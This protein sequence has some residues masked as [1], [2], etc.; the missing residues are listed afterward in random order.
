M[1]ALTFCRIPKDKKCALG[2][3]AKESKIRIW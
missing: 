3:R 1:I 2:V